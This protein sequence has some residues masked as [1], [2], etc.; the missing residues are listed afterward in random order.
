MICRITFILIIN[1]GKEGFKQ[2]ENFIETRNQKPDL[3]GLFENL[4]VTD[5]EWKAE[6]LP[7]I[8]KI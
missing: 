1:F 5:W 6:K 4:R 8:F 7:K 2:L 3:N